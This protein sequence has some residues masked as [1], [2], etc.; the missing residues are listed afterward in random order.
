[1][2]RSRLFFLAAATLGA[3]TMTFPAAAGPDEQDRVITNL[4]TDSPVSPLGPSVASPLKS[5]A[6]KK[7]E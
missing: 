3:L 2:I 6:P 1:M 4:Q 7:L 5:A